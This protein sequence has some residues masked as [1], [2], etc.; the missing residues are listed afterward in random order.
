MIHMISETVVHSNKT[1]THPMETC[2][3]CNNHKNSRHSHSS[4]NS[5]WARVIRHRQWRHPDCHRCNSSRQYSKSLVLAITTWQPLRTQGICQTTRVG[6]CRRRRGFPFRRTTCRSIRMISSMIKRNTMWRRVRILIRRLEVLSLYS[7][8]SRWFILSLQSMT[9][10]YITRRWSGMF[11]SSGVL[12]SC[13]SKL[14][15][16]RETY[17]HS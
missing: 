11:F 16:I 17:I 2:I 13:G 5:T 7:F 8:P 14:G 12:D 6:R 3:Q 10:L 9:S 4:I 1:R 15:R